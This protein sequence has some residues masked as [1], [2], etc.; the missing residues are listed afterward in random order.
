MTALGPYLQRGTL[1]GQVQPSLDADGLVLRPWRDDDAAVV[2]KAYREPD[3]CHFSRRTMATEAE[4][5]EWIRRWGTRWQEESG[6]NWAVCTSDRNVVG[7]VALSRVNLYEGDAELGYWVLPG[8][9]GKAVASRAVD[10][11]KRW[12]FGSAGLM[13]LQL[14]HSV[15]NQ[16]SCGVAGKTG[17]A[18]EGTRRSAL[19]HA[20]GWHDM[21]LHA[22]VRLQGSSST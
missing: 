7:R 5:L 20:D 16:G 18:L 17:F 22:A 9:R 15:H 14:S 2:V 8:D 1:S 11:L 6:A 13:R 10:A 4:A 12:A 3:I 19:R 21:H